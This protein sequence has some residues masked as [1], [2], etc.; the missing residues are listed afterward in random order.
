MFYHLIK[1][2]TVVILPLFSEYVRKVQLV[3]RKVSGGAKIAF[4]HCWA[5]PKLIES[6]RVVRPEIKVKTDQC[7]SHR[8]A[9]I[10]AGSRRSDVVA[11]TTP[12]D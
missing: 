1:H 9:G 7:N 5:R 2:L 10:R 4:Q 3:A 8:G 12:V 11:M 6:M